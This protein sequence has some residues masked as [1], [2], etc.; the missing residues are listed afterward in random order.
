[1]EYRTMGR[2]GL[3]LSALG[4]GSR[5][6]FHGQVDDQTADE[7]MDL[8]HDRGINFFDNA[9]TYA[10]GESEKTIGRVATDINVSGGQLI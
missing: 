7:I 5:I 6:G 1:M 3:Q 10:N 8:A 9:E 4:L 2:T